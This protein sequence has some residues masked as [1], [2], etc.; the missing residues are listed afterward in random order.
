MTIITERPIIALY[1]DGGLIGRNP[2]PIGGTWAW[3]GVTAGG[4]RIIE[5]SGSI[6]APG[7]RPITNNHTEFIAA[8]LALEAMP[9]GWSGKLYSDSQI[10]L[11]RLF[12]RWAIRNLPKNVY[13]RGIAAL[14][15]LGNV[16]PVLLQG[17]PT[18]AD[19]L[20]GIGAKR[21]LPVSEHNVWC[22]QACGREALIFKSNDVA[23]AVTTDRSSKPISTSSVAASVR[24][25][26]ISEVE[27]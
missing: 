1:A 19:L 15:R 21:G 6:P 22:D 7:G 24:P 18:K 4:V 10:T 12:W 2:S 27:R 25:D 9:D 20:H 26:H 11:G 8:T 23:P 16:E 14:E 17:H 5:R 3:C 13:V